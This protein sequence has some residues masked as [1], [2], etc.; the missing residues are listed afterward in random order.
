[1]WLKA[2]F[3]GWKGSVMPR[4]LPLSRFLLLSVMGPC[5][6]RCKGL[7]GRRSPCAAARLLLAGM[8][9]QNTGPH[10]AC[11]IVGALQQ[12]YHRTEAF[13]PS[14][15]F[16]TVRWPY[17]GIDAD[18]RGA[19]S[20]LSVLFEIRSAQRAHPAAVSVPILGARSASSAQ[21]SIRASPGRGLL[22]ISV[23]LISGRIYE[24]E[25]GPCRCDPSARVLALVQQLFGHRCCLPIHG[26]K[27]I[28]SS[29]HNLDPMHL[30]G[31]GCVWSAHICSHACGDATH[32]IMEDSATAAEPDKRR[33]P[34]VSV[35]GCTP[36]C[37]YA[38]VK[39]C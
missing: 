30:P 28:Y 34:G 13:A 27:Q 35:P 18:L 39:A 25:V 32:A 15:G 17:V 9:N 3:R 38:K 16:P 1:M 29:G 10:Y 11:A 14:I 37:A 33:L 36:S 21:L 20:V 31:H 24:G 4:E 2:R 23:I 8:T 7:L 26:C 22:P 6:T 12:F 19:R 5:C